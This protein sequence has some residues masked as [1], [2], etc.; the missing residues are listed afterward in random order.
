[1]LERVAELPTGV[2]AEDL[3]LQKEFAAAPVLC[4]VTGNLAAA[5]ARHGGYGHRQLLVRAGAAAHAAWLAALRLDL[6]GTVFAGLLPQVL[7]DRAG[8]DGYRR[9]PLFAFAAGRRPY[10][11]EGGTP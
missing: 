6:V 1:V 11:P 9:A 10:T 5:Q 2:G 7:R 4:T 3:V 8:A